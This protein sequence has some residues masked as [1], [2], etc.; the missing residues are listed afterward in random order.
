MVCFS[1][2]PNC[3]WEQYCSLCIL[4]STLHFPPPPPLPDLGTA[5][6]MDVQGIGVGK[7]PG[8]MTKAKHKEAQGQGVQFVRLGYEAR[9]SHGGCCS[10]TGLWTTSLTSW[11]F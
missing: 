2:A 5:E 7:S 1:L 3:I 4:T 8:Y 9:E 10:G 6:C 11:P